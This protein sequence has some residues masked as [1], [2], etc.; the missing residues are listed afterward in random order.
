MKKF[1]LGMDIGTDSVGMACTDEEYKLLRAKGQDLWSVRLFEEAQSALDRRVK[2][3]ARRRLQ[4][5]RQRIEFLQSVFAPFMQDEL[6]FI[7]LNNSGFYE[8]DKDKRLKTHFSLFADAEYTDADF[9]KEY[10]TIF[11]LRAKLMED[12]A[13][14]LR[15]YYLALHHIIKYRGHFLFEG[16]NM[17]GLRDIQKLFQEYNEAAS[18]V[19]E[20][21]DVRLLAEKSEEFRA[22]AMGCKKRNDCAFVGCKGEGCRTFWGGLCG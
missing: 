7:R 3:T 5:R 18:E 1:Y 22:L 15:L 17:S 21:V 13:S 12:G 19:L 6:F 10:P 14:D 8:E 16:E 2:R 11:H 4:R 9:Y 20:S